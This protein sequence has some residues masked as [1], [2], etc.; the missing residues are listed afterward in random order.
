MSHRRFED[1]K[2]EKRELEDPEGEGTH[3]KMMFGKVEVFQEDEEGDGELYEEADGDVYDEYFYD[4]RTGKELDPEMSNTAMK[5]GITFMRASGYTR[6]VTSPSVSRRPASHPSRRS[7]WEPVR[8][9]WRSQTS[10]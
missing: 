8:N 4:E 6:S 2:G 7:G 1:K 5:G 3:K 10:G 9:L